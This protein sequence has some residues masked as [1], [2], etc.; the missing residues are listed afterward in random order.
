[1]ARWSLARRRLGFLLGWTIV[2]G[3]IG[4]PSVRAEPVGLS[5][6]HEPRVLE[7]GRPAT[8][9]ADAQGFAVC[10]LELPGTP[11]PADRTPANVTGG[12]EVRWRWTVPSD[13]R[14]RNVA[15]SVACWHEPDP[16]AGA[17]DVRQTVPLRVGGTRGGT[18]ALAD[19]RGVRFFTRAVVEPGTK[20]TERGQFW[21]ALGGLLVAAIGLFGVA[22][23]LYTTRQEGRAA[24]AASL[25]QRHQ[26]RKFLTTKTA[27]MRYVNV[28]APV[29]CYGRLLAW[30]DA[31]SSESPLIRQ[32]SRSKEPV[33]A[34]NDCVNVIDFYEE[35]AA[36]F[37]ADAI[38]SALAERFFPDLVLGELDSYWW[39]V[40]Q[41]RGGHV[42]SLQESEGT[43]VV[44]PPA[45]CQP[46]ETSVYAE[47]EA[48]ARNM[49]NAKSAQQEDLGDTPLWIICLPGEDGDRN[50]YRALT[51]K[52]S[53]KLAD[54]DT[55]EETLGSQ[56]HQP[57]PVP[58]DVL[59][60]PPWHAPTAVHRRC[61]RL[62]GSIH[63]VIEQ[64]PTLAKIN[65]KL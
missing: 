17:P 18:L 4:P 36:L 12:R 51:K 38:D 6:G 30:A 49:R 44:K 33:P 16:A 58:T 27:A 10:A 25:M 32:G 3:V 26:D 43:F 14:S 24:R 50:R 11:A 28:D 19:A 8:V 54:L 29:G 1:M 21:I 39:L 34:M 13:A 45:G 35:L 48:L 31:R 42:A 57:D 60:I 23:Q 61:Q 22:Q 55:L 40:H 46:Y 62:A 65:N 64:D 56:S 53:G 5:I 41:F 9:A 2:A 52:L 15:V 63:D 59:C 47:W 7:A 20:W 37:N